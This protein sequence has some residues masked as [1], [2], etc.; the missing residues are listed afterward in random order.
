MIG[1][2]IK[3]LMKENGYTQMELALRSGC[4]QGSISSYING[5]QLPKLKTL[6][7]IAIAL[8][9]TVEELGVETIEKKC[10][11]C[12]KAFVSPHP[13]HIFCSDSCWQKASHKTEGKAPRT[14]VECGATYIPYHNRQVTCGSEEC[15]RERVNKLRREK[16]YPRTKK[17]KGT[18]STPKKRKKWSECTP[19]ERWERMTLTEL[20]GEIARLFPRK[21]YSDVRLLKERGELPE[22]FGK[23]VRLED[24]SK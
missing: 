14:C 1:E 4:K 3:R 10:K 23:D 16:K 6:K 8:G 11:H 17:P 12:G 19:A 5:K 24:C 7:N 22:E 2:N 9:V 21:S 18:T 15:Q 20:S 13:K